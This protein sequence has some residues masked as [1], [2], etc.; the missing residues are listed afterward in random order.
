MIPIKLKVIRTNKNE[1]IK[2]MGAR[3]P[4]KYITMY[5]NIA[6]TQIDKES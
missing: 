1:L 2:V 6:Y 5:D 4:T 3:E